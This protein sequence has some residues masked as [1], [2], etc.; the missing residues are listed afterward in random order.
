MGSRLF[1][2]RLAAVCVLLIG[3]AAGCASDPQP[4]DPVVPSTPLLGRVVSAPSCPVERVGQ[5]CPPT[6]V[7]GASVVAT[8][9]SERYEVRTAADGTFRLDLAP[10]HYTVTATNAG[11]YA[12]TA[13][14]RVVLR[15]APVRVRL[16]VD[17][18]IR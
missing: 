9:G 5:R 7:P 11:G 15:H 14:E 4:R 18:G 13:T 10:G 12:S 1:V 16:V 6:P 2:A 8:R 17:S 3:L